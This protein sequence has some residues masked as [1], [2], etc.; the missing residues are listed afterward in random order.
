MVGALIEH[1]NSVGFASI[2]Q[3]PLFFRKI[4]A[5]AQLFDLVNDAGNLLLVF[6]RP[7]QHAVEN[8]P[9]T[10]LR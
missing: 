9:Y 8:L 2:D 1:F 5:R 7:T 3:V 6:R 10:N 4:G